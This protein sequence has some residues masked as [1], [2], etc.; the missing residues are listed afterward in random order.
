[1]PC[2]ACQEPGSRPQQSEESR[3][4]TLEVWRLRKGAR[5]LRCAIRNDDAV[6]AGWDVQFLEGD[7]LVLSRRAPTE[8]AA[9]FIATSFRQDQVRD[10]WTDVTSEGEP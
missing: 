10:G 5:E 1:M 7:E 2:P 9:Q 8:G 3:A 6:G 4:S